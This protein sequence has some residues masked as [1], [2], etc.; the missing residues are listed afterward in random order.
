MNKTLL[1][2]CELIPKVAFRY[3]NLE[4]EKHQLE[5]KVANLENELQNRENDEVEKNK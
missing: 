5:K 1:R 3:G 4:D 2:L